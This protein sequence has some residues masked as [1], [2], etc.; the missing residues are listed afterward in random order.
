LRIARN[1]ASILIELR[2][3]IESRAG[4]YGNEDAGQEQQP[5][6]DAELF[7][8][9]SALLRP[10]ARLDGLASAVERDADDSA[11]VALVSAFL[12][13]AGHVDLAFR[14]AM[15]GETRCR[16]IV[17]HR[18]AKGGTALALGD[19]GV[20]LSLW[21]ARRQQLL[22]NDR[23]L[24]I[25][26]PGFAIANEFQR[27]GD[28]HLCIAGGALAEALGDQAPEGRRNKALEPD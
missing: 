13:V 10:G 18:D 17:G 5:S 24:P 7:K 2:Y 28:F 1:S 22:A 14:T 20:E 27:R 12:R 23:A 21:P 25:V 16:I 8:H 6:L 9:R 11:Q 19:R 26:R 3:Q 15:A 4:D